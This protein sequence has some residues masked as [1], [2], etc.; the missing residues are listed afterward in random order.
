[1]EHRV[2]A[3]TAS[4]FAPLVSSDHMQREPISV[5]RRDGVVVFAVRGEHDMAS[6]ASLRERLRELLT[7]RQPIVIDLEATDAIDSVILGVFLSAL[8]RAREQGSGLALVLPDDADSPVHR[9]FFM[10]GVATVFPIFAGVE[11]AVSA[12]SARY[13]R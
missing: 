10:T 11:T 5:D 9:L 8:R 1:V 7:E 6:A 2:Q 12:L 3:G 13:V 4:A